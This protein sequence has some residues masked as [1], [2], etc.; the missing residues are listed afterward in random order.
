MSRGTFASFAL[1][2]RPVGC[3]SDSVWRSVGRCGL[4]AADCEANRVDNMLNTD[5]DAICSSVFRMLDSLLNFRALMPPPRN[6]HLVC[7]FV[8]CYGIL[9]KRNSRQ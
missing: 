1:K 9:K 5:P 2:R 6:C 7:A 3:A 8:E 4:A